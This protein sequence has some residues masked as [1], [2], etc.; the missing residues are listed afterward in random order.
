M[1]EWQGAFAFGPSMLAFRGR[2]ADNTVHAHASVQITVAQ[3][4]QLVLVDAEGREHRGTGLVTRPG[5]RHVLQPH[6]DVTLVHVE[7][8]LPLAQ[9]LSAAGSA[10]VGAGTLP[11]APAVT[12][13]LQQAT[14]PMACLE[15]LAALAP[16]H[17]P[18][19]D[20]RI[21]RALAWLVGSTASDAIAQAA[22]MCG[23]SDSRLRV[24]ARASL[25]TSLSQW[26]MWRKLEAAG[27]AIQAGEPLAQAA[28]AGGFADQ[29]H[30]SR[31]MRKVFG[32]APTAVARMLRTP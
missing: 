4:G 30:F 6:A 22:T 24:L 3:T 13:S 29:A 7:P 11:L 8:H 25:G 18:V 21:A 26:L 27:R 23:V 16:P 15:V 12:A 2:A 1:T 31:T 14:S 5:Q 17:N 20:P 32:V 28:A 9:A 10:G 19:L